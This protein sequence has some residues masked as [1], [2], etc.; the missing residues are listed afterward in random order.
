MTSKRRRI[1][2]CAIV[3]TV[4]ATL[5]WRYA[6]S[7][8]PGEE[9]IRI[10]YLPIASDSSF[11]V[12]V[13]KGL[14][15]AVGL[16][17]EPIK[18]ETSNQALEALVTGRINATA[19]VAFEAA[20]AL[21]ANTPGQFQIIEMTAATAESKVHR[22]MVN[23][24]SPINTLADLCD[25]RV[26]TFPGTQMVTFLKLILQNFCADRLETNIIQL[27]PP[28]QPQALEQRQVDA[29]FCLEPTGTLLESR[30]IAR[31]ISVNPLYEFIQK[32]FPT[33][34]SLVSASLA[35]ERPKIVSKLMEAL[36][37]AHELAKKRPAEAA[38]ALPKYVP[39]EP[40]IAP[41]VAMYDYWDVRSIDK[42]AVQKLA[43]LYL[44]TGVLTKRVS[45]TD[46]YAKPLDTPS[47][48]K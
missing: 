9:L 43:D 45:T 25:K 37:A 32:P 27:K 48:N 16:Q 41:K 30:D 3:L 28:L 22:I 11:F 38:S 31:A 10:G 44:E 39:I 2:I 15:K 46:L 18:F 14:F 33:G 5:G 29:L 17:V 6:L 23:K 19:V 20:L 4:I 26:G 7:K 47:P 40:E 21:E 1:A 42:E 36:A 12:A 35:T 24:D 8:G 34:V 13:E